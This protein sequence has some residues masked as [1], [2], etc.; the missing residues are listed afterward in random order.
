MAWAQITIT[1]VNEKRTTTL[2]AQNVEAAQKWVK[3]NAERSKTLNSAIGKKV[4]VIQ[5]D[6]HNVSVYEIPYIK[7]LKH[8]AITEKQ[9]DIS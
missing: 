7:A 9:L 3:E 2:N 4:T 1:Y 5:H 8:Y 6:S